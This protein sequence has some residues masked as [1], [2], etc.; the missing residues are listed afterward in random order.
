MNAL[1]VI[2][3]LFVVVGVAV[4]HAGWSENRDEV[5]AD[6]AFQDRIAARYR[7]PITLRTWSDQISV[8]AP[9][10]SYGNAP[11]GAGTDQTAHAASTSGLAVVAHAGTTAR[12][13][14]ERPT[15]RAVA[16]RDT[17]PTSHGRDGL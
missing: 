11:H 2:A 14:G 7:T 6:R 17:V 3:A 15:S 5:R 9:T 10:W 4:V 16:D 13:A 12:D 1:Y 8:P